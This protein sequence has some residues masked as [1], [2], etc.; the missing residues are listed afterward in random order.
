MCGNLALCLCV[1]LCVCVASL[2]QQRWDK[3]Q[4]ITDEERL[5]VLALSFHNTTRQR[6]GGRDEEADTL[7]A[8]AH[9]ATSEYLF[10]PSPLT[11][12]GFILHLSSNRSFRGNSF[13]T[14]TMN[15][16]LICITIRRFKKAAELLILSTW[17]SMN[18]L[19]RS[20]ITSEVFFP[21][22]KNKTLKLS[23]MWFGVFLF[24]RFVFWFGV[25]HF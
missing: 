13:R 4:W 16:N 23:N 2:W 17:R 3:V 15:F 9:Q 18:I 8:H 14:I 22:H 12:K 7:H 21:K 25:S 10:L 24:I 11:Y 20:R 19:A 1:C 5:Q 6:E